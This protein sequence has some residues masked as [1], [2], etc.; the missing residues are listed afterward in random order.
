MSSLRQGKKPLIVIADGDETTREVARAVL[1]GA[2][3][4]TA[5]NEKESGSLFITQ[6]SNTGRPLNRRSSMPG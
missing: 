3:F 4:E 6:G 1:T 5:V 2:G